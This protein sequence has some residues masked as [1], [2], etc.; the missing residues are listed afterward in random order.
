V[1]EGVEGEVLDQLSTLL[2]SRASQIKED[3][4]SLQLFSLKGFSA[5]PQCLDSLKRVSFVLMLVEVARVE[6][7]GLSGKA[8]LSEVAGSLE[9]VD[10]YSRSRKAS[11][12]GG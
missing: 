4:K 10:C 6:E 2:G 5:S 8:S 7:I 3:C 12:V 9:V 11:R 1:A